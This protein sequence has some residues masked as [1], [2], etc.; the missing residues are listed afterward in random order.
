MSVMTAT[1][2][3]PRCRASWCEVAFGGLFGAAPQFAGGEVP[4]DLVVVVVA[5]QAQ[6]LAEDCG[7]SRSW[8]AQ[9]TS[10]PAVRAEAGVGVVGRRAWQGSGRQ[11]QRLPVGAGV[12]LDDAGVDGAE[13]G[14][15]EGGEHGRMPGDGVGDAFA[16]D[17][18]GAEELVGVALVGAGAGGADASRGGCRTPCRWRRRAA[19]GGAGVDEEPAG[20]GVDGVRGAGEPDRAGAAGG[21]PDVV[22][23]GVVVGSGGAGEGGG[24]RRCSRVGEQW[25][26]S[27][28]EATPQAG[29]PGCGVQRRGGHAADLGR[30][31]W[32]CSRGRWW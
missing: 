21:G 2:G 17:Q 12:P 14:G 13:R 4:D 26:G 24:R 5:V 1:K 9:Q 18:A 8:R 25:G 29:A 3:M 16:A 31:R 22:E 20:A 32:A 7:R 30:C 23:P 27:A 11:S 28:F 6:R 15:G 10:R 19:V